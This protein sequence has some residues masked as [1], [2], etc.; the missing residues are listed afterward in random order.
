[1]YADKL[2]VTSEV[3]AVAPLI[4]AKQR[5]IAQ[6]FQIDRAE[7]ASTQSQKIRDV[8]APGSG[9]RSTARDA[10]R[11]DQGQRYP[12]ADL[13]GKAARP[14]AQIS[15]KAHIAYMAQD[16]SG[17]KA[18]AAQRAD[19]AEARAEDARGPNDLTD[20]EEQ[21]LK[22]LKAR[23]A[24]VRRHEQAHAAVGGGYASAPTYVYQQGP[25]GRRYAIGG[26]VQIDMSP[27]PNDP[28]ATIAK[29]EVV[30]RAAMAPAEPSSADRSV[31]AAAQA[32]QAQA[33]ADLNAQRSEDVTAGLDKRA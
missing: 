24:E 32:A 1:M 18:T 29:M 14:E 25:D 21:M 15:L 11:D 6:R 26:S 3:M 13:R 8:A 9:A 31:A 19:P 30:R 28:E 16:G 27:V 22:D 12:T 7:G 4:E 33:L 5:E 2:G 23:D 17:D 20:A 10:M